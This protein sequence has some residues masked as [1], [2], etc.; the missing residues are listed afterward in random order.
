MTYKQW[1]EA[2]SR[3]LGKRVASSFAESAAFK[4]WQQKQPG[5]IAPTPAAAAPVPQ[6]QMAPMNTAVNAD[7]LWNAIL[8]DPDALLQAAGARQDYAATGAGA[9]ADWQT[10]RNQLAA[11]IPQLDLQ[12]EQGLREAASRTAARGTAQSGQGELE[13]QQVRTDYTNQLAQ[14]Q[15]AAQA[16][17]T[18]YQSTAANAA[19][20]YNQR[21]TGAFRDAATRYRSGQL[22]DFNN[23]Y[24]IDSGEGAVVPQ[25]TPDGTAPAVSPAVTPTAPKPKPTTLGAPDAPPAPT[26]TYKEFLAKH[27]GQNSNPTLAAK[28]RRRFA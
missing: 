13:K 26:M 25:A 27:P 12:Q 16:A 9:L 3:R 21:Y 10:A 14:N 15:L 4:D 7:D 17:D 18:G 2:R 20:D 8:K 5:Y 22:D 19:A 1:L 24:G 28:W 23:A 11:Q 6:P